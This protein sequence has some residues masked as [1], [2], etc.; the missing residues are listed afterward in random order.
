MGCGDVREG[1]VI[2]IILIDTP[3]NFTLLNINRSSFA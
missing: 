2:Y 1:V 3:V